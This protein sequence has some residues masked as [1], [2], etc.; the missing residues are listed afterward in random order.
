MLIGGVGF[1]LMFFFFFAN[2]IDG[3]LE[4]ADITCKEIKRDKRIGDLVDERYFSDD[5]EDEEDEYQKA[6][7]D[8]LKGPFFECEDDDDRE[9]ERLTADDLKAFMNIE[10]KLIDTDDRE[11]TCKD[12]AKDAQKR[13]EEYF[14]DVSLQLKN[15]VFL[16]DSSDDIE[17]L[18]KAL[19]KTGAEVKEIEVIQICE[20]E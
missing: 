5:E 6:L 12:D 20:E 10:K 13:W 11:K 8:D 17:E 14:E 18:E 3:T 16:G 1:G 15:W 19:E 2:N 7:E 9:Y 4:E